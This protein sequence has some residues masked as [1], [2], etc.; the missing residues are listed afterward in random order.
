MMTFDEA[1]QAVLARPGTSYTGLAL[2]SDGLHLGVFTISSD[3][4]EPDW[5]GVGYEGGKLFYPDGEED[6][7]DL[8][9]VPAVAKTLRYRLDADL[10]LITGLTSE[11]ALFALFPELPDPETVWG[12]D[13][14]KRFAGQALLQADTSDFLTVAAK[15]AW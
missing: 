8:E 14:Q 1:V 12:R 13:E 9:D 10:P 15:A 6:S 11:H 2:S 4:D 5:V 7:Y 3:V